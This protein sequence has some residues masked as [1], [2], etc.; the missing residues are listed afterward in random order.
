MTF[1]YAEMDALLYEELRLYHHP[2]AVTFLCTPEE[3]ENY[4]RNNEFLEPVKPLTFCQWEIAA[5]MQGK[6]VLGTAEKL[7]CSS[8]RIGFGWQKID[9]QEIASHL[10]YCTDREQTI[11]FLESKPRLPANSVLAVAVGPLGKAVLPPSVVH[12]YCDSMQAYNL[13]CDY[14]AATNTHPL[15]TQLLM[16][17]SACGGS[18]WSWQNTAFNF[19]T[20]CSGSYNAGKTE[21]GE[22][23]VFIPGAR[24][25]AVVKRLATRV[26]TASSSITRPGDCFPGSDI[27][28]N[29]PLIIFKKGTSC[30]NC[31]KTKQ[32]DKSQT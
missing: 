22:S 18:I 2:I 19:C 13:A 30:S 27:C 32:A 10:K 16:S 12:M 8:A 4:K 24:I 5:R 26:H 7:A 6:N 25:E 1:S 14:M 11:R 3:V 28:K 17:S 31:P 21:R 15:P 29:C 9:E 20:P 23:N